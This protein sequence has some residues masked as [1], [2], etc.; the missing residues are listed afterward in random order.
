MNKNIFKALIPILIVAFILGA[1][2]VYKV[3]SK[4]G[5]VS[6]LD[7]NKYAPVFIKDVFRAKDT[8]KCAMYMF[9]LDTIDLNSKEQPIPVMA[10][11]LMEAAK[12]GVEVSIVME[13]GEKDEITTKY[14]KITAKHLEEAGIKVVFDSEEERLHTKMC[15]IDN[16]IIYIGSHNY[17]NSAMLRNSEVSVRVVSDG[18]SKDVNLYF[19]KYGL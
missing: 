17:T 6:L 4:E 14:N 5:T 12:R 9:K 3:S 2:I 10:S 15:M 18:L 11:A 7:D 16:Q 13:L 8:I 1:N 19:E